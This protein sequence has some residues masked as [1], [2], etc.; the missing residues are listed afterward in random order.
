MSKTRSGRTTKK[1]EL[2]SN[3]K[4]KAGS[5]YSGCDSYDRSYDNGKFW[6]ST[7][8]DFR[9]SEK[10]FYHSRG[11]IGYEAALEKHLKTETAT[12]KLPVEMA[13]IIQSMVQKT[14]YQNDVEFI[15]PDDVPAEKAEISESEEEEW[16]DG[17]DTEDDCDSDQEWD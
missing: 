2:Y 17:S 15:A 9:Q 16:V 5:G 12:N 14:C 10:D 3:Q 1:P 8:D 6:N 13:N 4:F 11:D 7:N